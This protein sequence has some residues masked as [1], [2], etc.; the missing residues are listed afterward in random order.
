M[1]SPAMRTPAA[2]CSRARNALLP[3]FS[4]LWQEK[5]FGSI[6]LRAFGLVDPRFRL[7]TEL[8]VQ[9]LEKGGEV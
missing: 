3:C 8:K 1:Q 4:T 2:K 9:A 7:V 6:T 5:S